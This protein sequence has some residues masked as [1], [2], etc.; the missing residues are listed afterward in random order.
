MG[1]SPHCSRQWRM[2]RNDAGPETKPWPRGLVGTGHLDLAASECGEM[3]VRGD[4]HE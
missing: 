2:S 3:K 1:A 4:R